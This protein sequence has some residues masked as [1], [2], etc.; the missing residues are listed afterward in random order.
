[1]TLSEHTP[2]DS[3]TIEP[4]GQ[5]TWST[6]TARARALRESVDALVADHPNQVDGP[7]VEEPSS[8]D[9]VDTLAAAAIEP[10][11][12]PLAPLSPLPAPPEP[13]SSLG[14]PALP[15]PPVP[16]VFATTEAPEAPKAPEAPLFANLATPAESPIETAAAPIDALDNPVDA[17]GT[18]D[19]LDPVDPVAETEPLPSEQELAR[20]VEAHSLPD[21]PTPG[22]EEPA[23]EEALNEAPLPITEAVLPPPPPPPPAE[24]VSSLPP[25]P[26]PPPAPLEEPSDL[27]M[28]ETS[29]APADLP[30]PPPPPAPLDNSLD[31][32]APPAWDTPI[33]TPAAAENP[34]RPGLFSNPAP[35]NQPEGAFDTPFPTTVEPTTTYSLEPTDPMPF[36][37]VEEPNVDTGAWLS[38]TNE[39]AFP[40][41][42]APAA[43][44][45]TPQSDPAH[46]GVS[47][48]GRPSSLTNPDP[49]V[50]PLESW[51]NA[52]GGDWPS[53]QPQSP[54]V[55]VPTAT[56]ADWPATTP[57]ASD[58]LLARP[59]DL[60]TPGD[61]GFRGNDDPGETG[62]DFLDGAVE[63]E[64]GM[65]TAGENGENGNKGD[66][67]DNAPRS[68]FF[69]RILSRK[70]EPEPVARVMCGTCD[71][72]ARVDIDNPSLGVRHLSCPKCAKMWTEATDNNA[73]ALH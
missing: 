23:V 53:A 28:F 67:G 9:P 66:M 51:P 38:S 73:D 71:V 52:L 59:T 33:A 19:E 64:A 48:F 16:P 22:L 50:E 63:A 4:Q 58:P 62:D 32:P 46:E 61:L 21:S 6:A 44:F 49:Q 26:P 39:P 42:T 25:L 7:A 68:S 11:D 54:A 27:S 47:L 5:L 56:A 2:A 24:P 15:I 35:V 60:G 72:P 13:P 69:K 43:E 40:G 1:M 10:T 14:L 29:N 65:E 30:L 3:S 70:E 34:S 57:V 12:A 31:L 37:S 20:L 45:H 55:P 8:L 17:F 36:P 18:F 41:A